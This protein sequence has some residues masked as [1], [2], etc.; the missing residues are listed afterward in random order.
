I[1]LADGPTGNL[2]SKTEKEVITLITSI[3]TRKRELGMLQA[4]NFNLYSK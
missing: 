2:D 4:I 3:I 1:I